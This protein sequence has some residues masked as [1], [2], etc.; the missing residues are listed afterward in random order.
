MDQD[1]NFFV[2]ELEKKNFRFLK[3]ENRQIYFAQ[4]EGNSLINEI[5]LNLG[6]AAEITNKDNLH[7]KA[8]KIVTSY[9]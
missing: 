5:E 9:L 1:V 7:I 2:G 8:L 3:F 6:D 4:I